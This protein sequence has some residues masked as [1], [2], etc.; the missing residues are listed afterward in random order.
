MSKRA[1]GACRA[2]LAA[3]GVLALAAG[4]QAQ[5]AAADGG[6]YVGGLYAK[7]K[8][9]GD[10]EVVM[11][12]S[13]CGD[14]GL[15]YD[16]FRKRFSPLRVKCVDLF[17]PPLQSR[18]LAEFASTGPQADVLA[19]G[20]ADLISFMKQGWLQ[21]FLPDTAHGVPDQY[22]GPNNLWIGY[23]KDPFVAIYNTNAVPAD[24]APRSWQDLVD[25]AWRGKTAVS[26]PAGVNG[27]SQNLVAALKGG[28]IDEVWLTKLA[29]NK[30]LITP[31]AGAALQ[32]VAG[33]Q[34]SLSPIIAYQQYLNAKKQGAPLGYVAPSEGYAAIPA[35][36]ALLSKAPHPDAAKLLIAWLMT[37]DAQRLIAETG[38][39]G[40]MPGAPAP[41]GLPSG[42]NAGFLLDWR[43][44]QAHYFDNLKLF[45]K[46][47]SN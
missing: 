22:V 26:N 13:A 33:G 8:A 7:A 17:G 21:A 4:A 42:E 14:M 37:P 25:P 36:I 39:F 20:E 24:K 32:M 46:T 41:S 31:G 11:Y 27:V 2:A 28:V 19:D 29:A 6:A 38:Q 34:A 12:A 47:F 1:F 35:P 45:K 40:T 3:I 15:V 30:P 9:S 18:L 5:S 10:N 44:L 23:A 43:Y 16:A